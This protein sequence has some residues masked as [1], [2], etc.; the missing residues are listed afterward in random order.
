MNQ[1]IKIRII[2]FPQS[3]SSRAGRQLS[4]SGFEM[5]Q[6]VSWA[7]HIIKLQ[8]QIT[9]GFVSHIPDSLHYHQNCAC[10]YDALPKLPR[11]IQR[12]FARKEKRWYPYSW[13]TF[14]IP[15]LSSL[16]HECSVLSW[17]RKFFRPSVQMFF[18]LEGDLST[19]ETVFQPAC[20]LYFT[21]TCPRS[22]SC[23]GVKNMNTL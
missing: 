7:L 23:G 20:W 22:I 17:K 5:S 9:Q 8:L 19:L 18:L 2:W 16:H 10:C 11:Q 3:E 1:N 13:K 12:K 6:K 21:L 4:T 15:G 14:F